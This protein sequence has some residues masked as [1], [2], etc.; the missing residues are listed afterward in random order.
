MNF[1]LEPTN[2]KSYKL[3]EG[4][5]YTNTCLENAYWVKFEAAAVYYRLATTEFLR[6]VNRTKASDVSMATACRNAADAFERGERLPRQFIER[7]LHVIRFSVGKRPAR[8]AVQRRKDAQSRLNTKLRASGGL[9]D[10][11]DHSQFRA[12]MPS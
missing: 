8:A 4:G 10:L 6:L 11:V 1:R 2:F 9:K 5:A 3:V 7:Y 12:T